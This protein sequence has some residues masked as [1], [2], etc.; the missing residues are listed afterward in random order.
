VERKVMI[1]AKASVIARFVAG[2]RCD[3]QDF[4]VLAEPT[5][6]VER[7]DEG[8]AAESFSRMC[9]RASLLASRI[10]A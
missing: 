4:A 3:G 10:R 6:E 7:H 1:F 8:L 2:M 9:S 5:L